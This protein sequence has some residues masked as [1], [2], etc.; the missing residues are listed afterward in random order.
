[1]ARRADRS[2]SGALRKARAYRTFARTF[3][4]AAQRSARRRRPGL[5]G[6]DDGSSAADYYTQQRLYRE[7]L[8]LH[9]QYVLENGVDFAHFKY[10]HNTPIVPVFTRHDFDE[11]VSFVDFTITFEGD[12]NQNIEDIKSRVEAVNAG[13]GIA[14]IDQFKILMFAM[15][16]VSPLVLFL[17]KPQPVN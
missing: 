8:E 15:L 11:P 5:A 16:V 3:Q 6:F 17:R 14:V 7:S 9:P 13:L 10:V 2:R 1:M 12:D 4:L